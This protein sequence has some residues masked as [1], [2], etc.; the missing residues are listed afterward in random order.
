M[1]DKGIIVLEDKAT[2]TGENVVL[3]REKLNGLGIEEI[4]LIG[5]ISSKRRYVMTVKKQWPEIRR[6]CCHGVNYFS[7]GENQ[8]WEDREFRRRV[9]SEC[10]RISLYIDKNFI[11]EISIIDGIVV[12]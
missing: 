2:N 8:W 6:V 5:K 10:R 12:E 11:S 3:A 1:R 4:L 9:I 7:C